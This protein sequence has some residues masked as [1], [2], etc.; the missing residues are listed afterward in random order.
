VPTSESTRRPTF[1]RLLQPFRRRR[2]PSPDLPPADRPRLAHEI[3]ALLAEPETNAQRAAA[4]RL[5]DSYARLDETGRARFLELLAEDFG[6]DEEAVDRAVVGLRTATAGWARVD[7]ERALRSAVT[8][9]VAVLLH[10]IT[11][12]PDGVQFL[13]E[14]RADLLAHPERDTRL[15][16]LQDELTGHLRTL[17]DVGLLELRQITWNSPAS[18]L[19]RLIS[20]EAV[21]AIQGWEDLRHRL[22]G[23]LR[24][25][26]FFHPAMANEPIV[27]VEVALT[28]GLAE[29]LSPL[30]EGDLSLDEP[31]TAIFYSITSAQAGLAGVHLGNELI[32]QVV[33]HLRLDVDGLKTFATLSPLPGFRAWLLDQVDEGA[34]TP[35]EAE[36]LG[37]DA[38]PVVALEDRSWLSDGSTADRVRAAVLSA[39]AR[40]LTETVGGRARDPVANFHLSNGAS[41]ERLN[42]LANRASYGIEESL[43]VMVNYLYDRAKIAANARAYLSGA[44]IRTSGQ[45]RNLVKL[46]KP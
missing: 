39:A 42:W 36:L 46:T 18:V 31:D 30:L 28:R 29:S 43:G 10:V 16:L 37:E 9:R 24:C 45:I 5:L 17:F 26:G 20:T 11:G 2:G 8:P 1:D 3:E 35:A 19:E 33:D 34:L 32:K 41:L 22:D 13:V 25:Y 38:R 14:L 7:A 6:T 21:H 15:G 12:V 4:E 23:A 44:E 40:Y 27:F